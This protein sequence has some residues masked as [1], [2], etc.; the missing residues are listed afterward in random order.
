MEGLRCWMSLI[1]AY[2]ILVLKY[3]G[4]IQFSCNNIYCGGDVVIVGAKK[5]SDVCLWTNA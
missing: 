3:F 5:K 1:F 2:F 4:R